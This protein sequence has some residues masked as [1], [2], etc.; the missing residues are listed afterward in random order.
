MP[1]AART[2]ASSL[3]ASTP[4]GV[5]GWARVPAMRNSASPRRS[6]ALACVLASTTALAA[7]PGLEAYEGGD[8]ARAVPLLQQSVSDAKRPAAE[9]AQ[10]RLYLAASQQMLGDVS[11]AR[12]QLD[13]L[14]R[15]FPDQPVDPAAFVPEFVQLAESMRR[16]VRL[17]LAAAAPAPPPADLVASRS[18][19]PGKL[20]LQLGLAALADVAGT[21]ALTGVLSVGLQS[22]NVDVALRAAP[23]RAPAFGL[24]AGW[25]L[26][27][28]NVRPRV[29]ARATLY[30][31]LPAAA[32]TVTG[33]GLG[34]VAGLR[35]AFY[36]PLSLQ[37][38]A[39]AE[40]N[41]LP[42]PYRALTVTVSGGLLVRWSP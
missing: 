27:G 8:Y 1:E 9:R 25:S 33:V 19:A 41:A 37:A 12:T 38:D 35:W 10:S 18:Q 15:E 24:E 31:G 20:A 5:T 22:G 28:G 7:L 14:F 17:S 42:A 23:G 4:R 16:E 40:Y 36:G 39:S 6:L 26:G 13:L 32:G 3:N 11:A 21:P 34:P 2:E 30:P 29:G